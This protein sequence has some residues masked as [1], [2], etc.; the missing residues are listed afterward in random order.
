MSL[1]GE[2]VMP[3]DHRHPWSHV[4]KSGIYYRFKLSASS[5]SGPLIMVVRLY[6]QRSGLFAVLQSRYVCQRLLLFCVVRFSDQPNS[7]MFLDRV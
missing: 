7:I 6:W 5:P 1:A 4:Q 2:E 3:H